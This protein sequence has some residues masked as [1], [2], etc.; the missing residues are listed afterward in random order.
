MIPY[1]SDRM[2]LNSEYDRG[3][4]TGYDKGINTGKSYIIERIYELIDEY[5]NM[6]DCMYEVTKMLHEEKEKIDD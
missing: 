3:Y 5:P 6:T 4:V 2:I 1:P